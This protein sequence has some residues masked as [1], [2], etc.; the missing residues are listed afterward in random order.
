[1]AR[2]YLVE[3]PCIYSSPQLR[4]EPHSLSPYWKE[5]SKRWSGSAWL[6]LNKDKKNTF[7]ITFLTMN[8]ACSLGSLT[9]S[10]PI[11]S[12]MI[13]RER[14]SR[15]RYR[16]RITVVNWVIRRS[17]VIKLTMVWERKL[18]LRE[19]PLFIGGGCSRAN[20][21]P[22][23]GSCSSVIHRGIF[24]PYWSPAFFSSFFD[25]FLAKPMHTWI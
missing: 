25:R 15:M 17:I 23:S 14:D 11:S 10:L 4:S 2:A 1:M 18:V 3:H 21:V 12:A 20:S 9:A 16:E 6:N 19:R 22:G 8:S 7:V 24:S 5:C 13:G